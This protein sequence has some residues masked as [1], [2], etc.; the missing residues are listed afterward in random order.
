MNEMHEEPCEFGTRAA[1]IRGQRLAQRQLLKGP[2]GLVMWHWQAMLQHLAA[3]TPWR[4]VL[5]AQ[6]VPRRQQR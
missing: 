5:K 3:G 4:Q 2:R 6:G 1:R